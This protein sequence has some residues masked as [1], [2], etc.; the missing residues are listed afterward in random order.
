[1]AGSGGP[2]PRANIPSLLS[3]RAPPSPLPVKAV[4]PSPFVPLLSFAPALLR[5]LDQQPH[6][7][8]QVP[9]SLSVRFYAAA[10]FFHER[11]ERTGRTVA[12][13]ALRGR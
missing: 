12:H 3:E 5:L 7:L 10:D 1:M 8:P 9:A 2:I 4:P 13:T 6:M 11:L